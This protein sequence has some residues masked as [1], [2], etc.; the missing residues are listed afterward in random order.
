[1]F[2]TLFLRK[3][4]RS[5]EPSSAVCGASIRDGVV[6]LVLAAMW[7]LAVQFCSGVDVCN[8]ATV[9]LRASAGVLAVGVGD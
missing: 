2:D 3:T 8:S 5:I 1:M 4:S 9:M 6:A 7:I